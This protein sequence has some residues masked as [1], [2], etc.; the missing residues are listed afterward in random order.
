[1][2]KFS[3]EF[4]GD[5][6]D[7]LYKTYDEWNKDGFYITKG[8]KA[9]YV[10]DSNMALFHKLQV[11]RKRVPYDYSSASYSRNCWRSYNRDYDASNYDILY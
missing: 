1:M 4:K 10:N 9:K 5:P 7:Y 3:S 8:E 6:I 11:K 2:I